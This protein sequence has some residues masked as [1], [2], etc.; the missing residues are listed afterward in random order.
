MSL[1]L[2]VVDESE[3]LRLGV[4]TLVGNKRDWQ[5]CGEASNGVEAIMK[6][7]ELVPDVVILALTMPVKNGFQT[8][9]ELRRVAP[10]TKIVFFSVH[11]VPATAREVGADAFV[12]KTAPA[13]ELTRAIE[14]VAG[15]GC[16]EPLSTGLV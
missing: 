16:K 10:S 13:N 15:F 6:V 3:V 11:D 5:I 14:R 12:L 4:R 2:L 7:Q 1:R 9:R 8:A